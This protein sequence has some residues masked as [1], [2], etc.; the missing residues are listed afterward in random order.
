MNSEE[1][2]PL[3]RSAGATNSPAWSFPVSEET[4]PVRVGVPAA[5]ITR[6][7]P[8]GR[9]EN[10]KVL[11]ET[12]KEVLSNRALTTP[13]IESFRRNNRIM[14]P[15]RQ[16]P[17]LL[18][19]PPRPASRHREPARQEL[20]GHGRFHWLH[21]TSE[22]EPFHRF[23]RPKRPC[24]IN[25]APSLRRRIL[26][27]PLPMDYPLAAKQR[28]INILSIR[29]HAV[30]PFPSTFTFTVLEMIR[31]TNRSRYSFTLLELRQ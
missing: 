8:P 11:K 24:S 14:K 19:Q 31:N 25:A 30:S 23:C 4:S 6:R 7:F 20:P 22:E 21:E 16:A 12:G 2:G 27:C 3:L 28:S 26:R 29:R 9:L 1:S 15:S 5:A 17:L 13:I 18:G 10:P